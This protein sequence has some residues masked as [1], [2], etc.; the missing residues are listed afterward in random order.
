MA[1]LCKLHAPDSPG[2]DA[3]SIDPLPTGVEL[4]DY[5]YDEAIC[6]TDESYYYQ[7]LYLLGRCAQPYL[8]F[9]QVNLLFIPQLCL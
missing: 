8:Q 5:L 1:A 3:A 9:V 4:L 6:C 2:A 7:L